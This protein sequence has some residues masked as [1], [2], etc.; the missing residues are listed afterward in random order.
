MRA[1]D[2][3]GE[4]PHFA[5]DCWCNPFTCDSCEFEHHRM[6]QLSMDNQPRMAVFSDQRA[7]VL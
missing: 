6:V 5:I 1:I 3:I 4:R 2:S 7:Y